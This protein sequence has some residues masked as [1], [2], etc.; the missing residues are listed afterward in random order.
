MKLIKKVI[1]IGNGAAVYVP[2]EFQGREILV[3]LPE[4]INEVRNRILTNLIEF[5]PNIIGVYIYGS[6][7]RNEQEIDSD[8]DIL[9]ITKEK[10][11]R[12]KEAL[13][14][15][16]VRVMIL[17]NLKKSIENLPALIMPILKEAKTFLNPQLISD[18][19]NLDIN[20]KKFKWNFDDTKRIIKIIEKF[21]KI[22]DEDIA[23]SHIYSLIM[24]I[25][26]CYMIDSLLNNKLFSNKG[27][28][29][30][31]INYGLN[32]DE[33]YKFYDIYRKVRDNRDVDSII[34]KE[35]ILKLINITKD[36]L[37]RI[38]NETKKKIRKRN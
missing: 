33:I 11:A 1:G 37:I 26:V 32:K 2:K 20:F 14:E 10:D 25:R 13:K 23:S 12:I 24:R 6:Y 21:I 9:I 35:E 8:I 5:M 22:D 38:E 28:E 29:T 17:E 30:L 36:Y 3:V 18:L 15:M 31:L 7:A 16:D 34:K 4:G 27:V 19:K